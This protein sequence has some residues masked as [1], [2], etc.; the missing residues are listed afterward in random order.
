MAKV[1]FKITIKDLNEIPLGDFVSFITM[2]GDEQFKVYK[3][4]SVFTSLTPDEVDQI[5]FEI[6]EKTFKEIEQIIT[7]AKNIE[8]QPKISIKNEEFGA[9]PNLSKMTFG[10]YIDLD[11]YSKSLLKADFNWHDATRLMAVFYRPVTDGVRDIYSIEP[12]D[13]SDKYNG[14]MH[15]CPTAAFFGSCAFF[16]RLRR[17]LLKHSNLFLKKMDY[18]MNLQSSEKS[19]LNNMVGERVLTIFQK[20]MSLDGTELPVY[21]STQPLPNLSTIKDKNRFRTK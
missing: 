5:P 13:G 11:N 9:I 2:Q 21:L 1:Q 4:F 10:E 16:L 18:K 3:A 19:S 15:D 14:I 7:D 6:V 8:F 12:Y 17:G 20:V